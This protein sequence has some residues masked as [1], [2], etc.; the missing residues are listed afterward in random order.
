MPLLSICIPT[1]NRAAFLPETLDSVVSQ[2]TDDLEIT[3][4]DNASTDGTEALVESYRARYGAVRYFRWD[5]NQGADRNFLKSVEL[6]S[7]KYCWI[8]GSDDPIYPGAVAALLRTIQDRGPSIVLFNRQVCRK[9]LAPI[10]VERFLDLDGESSRTYDF[11]QPGVLEAY[12][13]R[14]KSLCVAFSYLS[15]VAFQKRVWDEVATDRE[16]LGTAYIHVQKLLGACLKGGI[17]EYLDAPYVKCRLGNDSF[18]ELGLARRMLL[19]LDGYDLLI[20]RYVEPTRPACADALR[21]MVRQ[22]YPFGRILRYQGVIGQSEEWP[23][24]LKKLRDDYHYSPRLA[25]LATG[26]GRSRFLVDFSFFLR[27]LRDHLSAS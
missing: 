22:E 17:L 2:W 18:R 21:R 19:D 5:S 3:V 9:D 23:V 14:A 1:Y 20:R 15:S 12:L 27:N 10:K 8:L 24:I 16:F 26:L 6:A 7:G 4:A 11:S 13:Q 25:R